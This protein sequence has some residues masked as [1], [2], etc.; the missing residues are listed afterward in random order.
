MPDL[1]GS[2]TNAGQIN[3][4][5]GELASSRGRRSFVLFN[6]FL[7]HVIILVQFST[8][9]NLPLTHAE[10]SQLLNSVFSG[11]VFLVPNAIDKL[12]TGVMM[13]GTLCLLLLLTALTTPAYTARILGVVPFPATSHNILLTSLFKELANRGHHL[14]VITPLPLKGNKPPNYVEIQ[15]GVTMQDS[16]A[17]T[18]P[19]IPSK[20]LH[21]SKSLP[22]QGLHASKSLPSKVLQESKILPSKSLQEIKSF[23][24]K[25]R[26]EVGSVTAILT[27]G[28]NLKRDKPSDGSV[29][30]P[31]AR[32]LQPNITHLS[33]SG[34]DPMIEGLILPPED[35]VIFYSLAG[36]K[37]P[38]SSS[39]VRTTG[40]QRAL[41]PSDRL[42]FAWRSPPHSTQ[43]A[44][45]PVCLCHTY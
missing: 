26:Q 23:P 22:S 25:G 14:T 28:I 4:S 29:D 18:S 32:Q 10:A 38:S 7:T 8:R 42:R 40:I 15:T 45:N 6:V 43:P 39:A 31:D 1:L 37:A 17:N 36:I 44:D 19:I 21:E 41:L 34:L 16:F 13:I 33:P 20:G 24:S 12:T 5:R 9:Y 3:T 35:V 2:L 11:L 27:G 30:G